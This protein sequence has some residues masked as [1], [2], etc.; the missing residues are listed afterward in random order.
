MIL[1]CNNVAT[2]IF[3]TVYNTAN[4]YYVIT[5]IT[6]IYSNQDEQ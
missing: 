1:N 4:D 2:M 6:V 5:I 3:N